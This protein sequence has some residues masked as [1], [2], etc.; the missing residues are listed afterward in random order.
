[1]NGLTRHQEFYERHLH[2]PSHCEV[3]HSIGD[4]LNFCRANSKAARCSPERI[5]NISSGKAGEEVL[6]PTRLYLSHLTKVV[7]ISVQTHVI[8]T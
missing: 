2:G 7:A 6:Q 4:E 8:D 3:T 5:W 1:M